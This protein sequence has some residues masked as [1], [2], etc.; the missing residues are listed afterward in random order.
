MV[1]LNALP[2]AAPEPLSDTLCRSSSTRGPETRAK[3]FDVIERLRGLLAEADEDELALKQRV[4]SLER[5]LAR[6]ERD[7]ISERAFLF[8]QQD[9][10]IASLVDEHAHAVNEL[11]RRVA[12][13]EELLN[14][15]REE[16]RALCA[17]V[18]NA[19]LRSEELTHKL[20]RV[21]CE[22][23]LAR[24]ASNRITYVPLT[25]SDLGLPVPQTP[26]RR[27]SAPIAR[28]AVTSVRSLPAGAE[29]AASARPTGARSA[30][31]YGASYS[32]SN[33]ELSEP[34]FERVPKSG[35]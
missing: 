10:F 5:A 25:A 35:R 22:L 33:D 16:S 19:R 1:S 30:G 6:A 23:E 7:A 26:S 9:A 28:V 32:L 13:L 4:V 14:E 2:A 18:E 8:E 17:T 27:G 31:L 11:K 20:S 15:S 21:E 24:A 29:A 12:S 34:A 3:I